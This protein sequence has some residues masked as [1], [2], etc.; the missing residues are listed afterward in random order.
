MLFA[1]YQTF[2]LAAAEQNE[3]VQPANYTEA[4]HIAVTRAIVSE[5]EALGYTRA[6]GDPDLIIS[7]FVRLDNVDVLQRAKLMTARQGAA[8]ARRGS[9]RAG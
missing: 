7:A 2:D 6:L 4:N 5:M 1:S 8:A 3:D 9:L